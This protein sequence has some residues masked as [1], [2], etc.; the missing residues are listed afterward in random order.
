MQ[1]PDQT[2]IAQDQYAS[3]GYAILRDSTLQDRVMALRAGFETNFA[4]RFTDDPQRN[5][6]LIKR[7][8]DSLGAARFFAAPEIETAAH[9]LGI[10]DPVFCG[11]IITHY[12]SHDLTGGSYGL[13][14]HQDWRSMGSSDRCAI[15]WVSLT[16]SGP[17]THGLEVVPGAHNE[18]LF[19]WTD[20]RGDAPP[21]DTPG[22]LPTRVLTVGPG[23]VVLM[24]ALLPHRT[25]VHPQFT[26][27][28]LSLSRRVDD[29]T[30][31]A[32]AGRGF[33]NA[34][35]NAVDRGLYKKWI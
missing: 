9:A 26:G 3:Q 32:W 5:R 16:E 29:L 10:A 4:S 19:D 25:Y 24:S 30:C 34:Y 31:S 11:P 13:P 8:G 2:M 15:L 18:G 21:P 35:G 12:T 33:A 14:Y 7:F 17:Q 20:Q 1:A 28:K 27:W 23:D 22:G 6:N